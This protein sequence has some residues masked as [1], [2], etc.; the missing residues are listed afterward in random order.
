MFT[1]NQM[2]QQKAFPI[3]FYMLPQPAK[4]SPAPVVEPG[5]TVWLLQSAFLC[6][7]S[8]RDL[9]STQ[10]TQCHTMGPVILI[11]R[12]LTAAQ[13]LHNPASFRHNAWFD[14]NAAKTVK[15]HWPLFDGPQ[16]KCAELPSW[17]WKCCP[18]FGWAS[19]GCLGVAVLATSG[20]WLHPRPASKGSASPA[21]SVPPV[22]KA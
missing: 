14:V 17:N 21:R 3:I 5:S 22:K 18:C 20:R 13:P 16:H 12:D 6:D 4:T 1:P 15:L 9:T 19:A 10:H 7:N 8:L 2:Q 11:T